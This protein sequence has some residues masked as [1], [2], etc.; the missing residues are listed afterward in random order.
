M[1]LD[2]ARCL[3][4]MNQHFHLRKGKSPGTINS[5]AFVMGLKFV[6]KRWFDYLFPINPTPTE[7]LEILR[8][9]IYFVVNTFNLVQATPPPL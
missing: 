3:E 1:F 8:H 6:G 9:S 7:T 2:F 4:G 5:P